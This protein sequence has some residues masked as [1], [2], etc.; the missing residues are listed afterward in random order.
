MGLIKHIVRNKAHKQ[1]FFEKGI[2]SLCYYFFYLY[3]YAIMLGK[4]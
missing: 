3:V 4:E 1:C 2:T